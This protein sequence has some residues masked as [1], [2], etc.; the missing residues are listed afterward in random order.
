MWVRS[1]QHPRTL[2]LFSF[3]TVSCHLARAILVLRN[4][5]ILRQKLC[6][7]LLLVNISKIL[8][9]NTHLRI[10]I[11]CCVDLGSGNIVIFGLIFFFGVH[12]WILLALISI[13]RLNTQV[14]HFVHLLIWACWRISLNHI[15]SLAFLMKSSFGAKSW[16]KHTNLFYSFHLFFSFDFPVPNIVSWGTTLQSF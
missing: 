12:F 14:I 5:A 16:R 3:A 6:L 8:C 1:I 2:F 7:T 15:N 9:S 4:E 10:Q 11:L 13:H